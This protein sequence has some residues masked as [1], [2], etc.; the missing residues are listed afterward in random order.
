MIR[1]NKELE[2]VIEN[3]K[4]TQ[5]E[6]QKSLEIDNIYDENRLVKMY[7]GKKKTKYYK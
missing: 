3:S 2:K 6:R 5:K 1:I 4:I 7:S